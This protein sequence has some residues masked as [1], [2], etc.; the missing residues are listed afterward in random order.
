MDADMFETLYTLLKSSKTSTLCFRKYFIVLH[1]KYIKFHPNVV[2]YVLLS[3][4]L[5]KHAVWQHSVFTFLYMFHLCIT[6]LFPVIWRHILTCYTST[7]VFYQHTSLHMV[8][9][10]IPYQ[11]VDC[12]TDIQF[13]HTFHIVIC[14]QTRNFTVFTTF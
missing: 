10:E 3:G 8:L 14:T 1:R 2:F 7:T 6:S 9:T 4:D 5:L 11:S 12:Q 13:T